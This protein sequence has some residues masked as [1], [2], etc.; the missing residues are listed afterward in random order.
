MQMYVVLGRFQPF[1]NGH[2]YLVESALAL[3]P[4]TIAI[5]SS[6]ESWTPDNPWSGD[7]REAMIRA[8]LGK[9]EAKIVQI[10]DIND[11]P[12][13]VGHAKN[14]HGEGIIVTSDQETKNLYEKAGWTVNWVELTQ[15]DSFEGWKV[16]STL[17][18][19]STVVEGDAQK[20]V[21]STVL[22]DEITEW[23]LLNDGLYRF[24]EISK[25]INHVG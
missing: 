5:G 4:I 8:W 17:K 22:P 11:P 21:M 20:E 9:R 25:N 3:G 16:R 24:Y 19:L 15:R 2:A 13:W 18:M 6:Q 14:T 23:L 7:E 10:E 12:N 1:H